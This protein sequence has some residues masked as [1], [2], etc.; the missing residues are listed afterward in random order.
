MNEGNNKT[1]PDSYYLLLIETAAGRKAGGW[2][3]RHRITP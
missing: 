1:Y 3:L 2:F